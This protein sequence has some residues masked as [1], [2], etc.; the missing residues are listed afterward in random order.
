MRQSIVSALLTALLILTIATTVFSAQPLKP[1]EQ[2]TLYAL[3]AY[4]ATAGNISLFNLSAEELKY[5]QQGFTDSALN[6]KLTVEPDSYQD[7][8]NQ[9]AQTRM[10]AAAEVQKQKSAAYLEKA[11]KEKGAKKF[12]SGLIMTAIKEGKGAQPKSTDTVKVHY[13]GTFIDGKVF[14]S[15]VKRG[16]P[17]EFPLNNV[18][19]CWTEG[20]GQM[21]VGGKS[22]L[23][24][25]SNIA[26]GDMGRPP[27]IPGGA[28]LV[29]EIELLDITKK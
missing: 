11:A 6:R 8:I 24:C 12:P 4:M 25:P 21:K 16:E 13:T 15:S 26:Y 19:P 23:V 9:L 14:D 7:K 22:K 3:G 29:F 28:T 10:K 18:I 17:A 5:V 2:K 20:V 27:V 1:E